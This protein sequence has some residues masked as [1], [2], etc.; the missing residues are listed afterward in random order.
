MIDLP[1]IGEQIVVQNIRHSKAIVSDIVWVSSESRFMIELSWQDQ[2]DKFIG[3]SKIY[4]HDQ[5][6]VWFRLISNN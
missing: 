5:N 2:D 4:H 3:K 1:E 6:K